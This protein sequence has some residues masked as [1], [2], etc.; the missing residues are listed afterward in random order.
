[1]RLY[2]GPNNIPELQSYP[3]AERQRQWRM[4]YGEVLLSRYALLAVIL[5]TLIAFVGI[6]ASDAAGFSV[7]VGRVAG[8]IIGVSV[9]MAVVTT[10]TR[11]LIAQG[12]VPRSR[13]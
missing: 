12:W 13:S 2:W 7:W 5:Y 4:C 11:R 10:R 6:L 1:M 8:N 9:A 3:A